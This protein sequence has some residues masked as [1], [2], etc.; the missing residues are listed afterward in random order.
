MNGLLVLRQI[1][2]LDPALLA[3][4]EHEQK[5]LQLDDDTLWVNND[6]PW[7]AE[8]TKA[9]VAATKNFMVADEYGGRVAGPYRD[10]AKA[11]QARSS[12][13]IVLVS[14]IADVPDADDDDP[15]G[16]RAFLA[17]GGIDVNE[18]E[19]A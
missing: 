2:G 8:M 4:I 16:V 19:L 6:Q 5:L 18:T 11:E 12:A 3:D 14:E 13:K 9:V 7:D 10:L 15:E 1:V 17:F